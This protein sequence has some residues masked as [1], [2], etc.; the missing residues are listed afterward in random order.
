M[1]ASAIAASIGL[2][3]VLAFGPS[4]ARAAERIVELNP[5]SPALEVNRYYSMLAHGPTKKFYTLPGQRIVVVVSTTDGKADAS[6]VIHVFPAAAT[7]D[8]I[9]KWINNQHSDALFA[10]AAQPQRSIEVR[11]ARFHVT[12]G[13]PAGHEVGEVGD[14]Y[15]RVPVEFTIDAF[16]DGDVTVRPSRG[17]LDA[18]VRTKAAAERPG[19]ALP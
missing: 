5:E 10:D 17:R 9:D 12:V 3:M 14:E 19:P 16:T 8:D 1:R 11:A 13:A 7:A 4:P 6:A 15:D 18:F 2:A